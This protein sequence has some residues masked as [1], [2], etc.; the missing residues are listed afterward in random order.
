[1]SSEHK[2]S[3]SEKRF[4]SHAPGHPGPI[5]VP[6]RPVF[7]TLLTLL[8]LTASLLLPVELDIERLSLTLV[9]AY[10]EDVVTDDVNEER[11]DDDDG[12]N[13]EN[14]RDAPNGE[15]PKSD[16]DAGQESEEL[17][18]GSTYRAPGDTLSTLEGMENVSPERERELLGSWK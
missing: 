16:D 6:S 8:V 12:N 11:H 9:T 1:M 14:D 17:T 15:D 5:S 3:H 7:P 10:A 4:T 18:S 13:G 2:D